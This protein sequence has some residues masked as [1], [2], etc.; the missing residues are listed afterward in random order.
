MTK[1]EETRPR[2]R[3]G[4]RSA[5]V[6]AAVLS[7]TAELL[8]EG[9]YDFVEV[10]AVARRAGV[11]PTTIYRRWPTKARLVGEALLERA[12]TLSPTPDTG[13]LEGDLGRLIQE[14]SALVRTPAVRALFQVLLSES[15]DP[16]PE[17]AAAR[18]RFWA[19]HLV[20]AG[21]I[22]ERAVARGE[23]PSGTEPG[24]LVDLIVGPAL[25]RLLLMGQDLGELGI[26]AIV[27]RAMASLAGPTSAGRRHAARAASGLPTS[28]PS[29]P[30]KPIRQLG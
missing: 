21:G 29:P 1:I 5:R 22:V 14:G 6:R 9:G 12:R 2:P 7:A 18:D 28:A 16:A 27:T 23:L 25:F 20:E 26:E 24:A 17:I 4:G 11:H 15:T 13:S 19:A 30:R 10:S 8:A 3:T